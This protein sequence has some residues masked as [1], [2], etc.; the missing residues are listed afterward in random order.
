[1]WCEEPSDGE[2][3]RNRYPYFRLRSWQDRTCDLAQK[4]VNKFTTSPLDVDVVYSFF[5]TRE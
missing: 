5:R 4:A 3:P 1:M 2:I